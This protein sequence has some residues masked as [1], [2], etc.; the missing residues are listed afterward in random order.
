MPSPRTA[1]IESTCWTWKGRPRRMTSCGSTTCSWL[2]RSIRPGKEMPGPPSRWWGINA[3]GNYVFSGSTDGPGASNQF[4]AYNADIVVREGDTVDGVEILQ[5]GSVRFLAISDLEQAA[6]A[7]GYPTPNGF[8]ESVFFACNAADMAAT[9]QVV[10]TTVDDTLDID[11]DGIGDFTISDVTIT[12]PTDG[13]ALGESLSVFVEV[14]LDD[15]VNPTS[16]AM[17]EFPVTCC[18]NGL[19][20]PQEECDDANAEDTDDCLS[21]CVAASCGDGFLQDGVEECDDGNDDDTDDCPGSCL[22]ATCGEGFVLDGV[23]ECD[24]GNDDDT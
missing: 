20:D 21:S 14:A 2:G 8:R 4:L 17:V 13:R 6:Y 5:G 7:W 19:V 3:A 16:A 9:S 12:G 18:G 10:F 1:R 24:D 23:E 22:A 15:G 11:D